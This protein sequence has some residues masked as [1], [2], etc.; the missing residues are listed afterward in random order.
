MNRIQFINPPHP[1]LRQPKAQAP[2]GM[3]YV[4]AAA[5]ERGVEVALTDLSDRHWND[6][7]AFDDIP[8]ASLYGIT[9]T[10]LD[11]T[12]CHKVAAFLKARDKRCRVVIGGPITLSPKHIDSRLFDAYVAGEGEHVIMDVLRDYPMLKKKY[13]GRRIEDL[14]S[15]PHPA[16]DLLGD[17]LGGDVFANR[18][19]Y[20]EGGSTVFVTSRGCP[21]QCTFCAS[22]KLWNRHLVYRDADA[23]A[24][25][26]DEVVARYGVRQ[27]RFSDDNV[28]ANRDHL[29]RICDRLG[30]KE[31]AWRASIR[32]RPNDVEMFEMMRRGGCTEVCFGIESGDDEVLH[33]LKKGAS[34]KDNRTAVFNAKKAGLAVRL[35]MMMGAPGETVRTV[36][37]NIEFLESIRN[38]YDTM[39]LTNFTPLPGC[40]I[41]DEP[42]KCGAEILSDDVD[43]FNL[44]F[45]GPSGEKNDFPNL[46]RPVGLTLEQLTENKR[47]MVEYFTSTGKANQG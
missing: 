3:L 22:P 46:V 7:G 19:R 11:R 26:V 15:L 44:C 8:E 10:I 37:R 21:F 9:G 24:D 13:V 33:V 6:L 12:P 17:D 25:E 2:L 29:T 42:A 4:A 39:A 32:V 16:R 23:V 43:K 47:R 31:I 18:E 38:H 35:L 45:Y 30:G 41:A 5:R 14:D 34:V 40:Q 28:T 20:F 36:D 1:Y 27:F